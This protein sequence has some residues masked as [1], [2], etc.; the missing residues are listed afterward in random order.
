MAHDASGNG[1]DGTIDGGPAWVLADDAKIGA[2][3]ISFDGVDDVVSIGSFDVVSSSG[4]KC[5]TAFREDKTNVMWSCA[6]NS[7]REWNPWT[8]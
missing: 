3:A 2:G 6:K 7:Y 4:I 1:H 8:N 5:S